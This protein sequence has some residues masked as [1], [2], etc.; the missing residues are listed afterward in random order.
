MRD[1]RFWMENAG[2]P[3]EKAR[4]MRRAAGALAEQVASVVRST[5]SYTYN[6]LVYDDAET[7]SVEIQMLEQ[8]RLFN[9]WKATKEG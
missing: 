1:S 9:E 6:D 8:R 3:K 4:E 5:G 2:V 7:A